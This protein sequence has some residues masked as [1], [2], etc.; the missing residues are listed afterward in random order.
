MRDLDGIVVVPVPG[1]ERLMDERALAGVYG[2]MPSHLVV[3]N[4]GALENMA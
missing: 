4:W 1:A 2:P 3:L